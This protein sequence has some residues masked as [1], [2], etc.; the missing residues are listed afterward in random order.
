MSITLSSADL[1]KLARGVELL[2]SPLDHESADHWRSAVNRHVRELLC[3]DTAGFLLPVENGLAMYSDEHDPL[4]LAAFNEL[5]PPLLADGRTVWEEG[6]R[7]GVTTVERAYGREFDR[8]RGSAYYHEYAAVNRANDTLGATIAVGSVA[9][10]AVASLHFWHD[11]PVGRLFGERELGLLRLLFPA[12]QAGVEAQIRWGDERADLFRSLDVLGHAAI[13][14]NCAGT[15]LHQTPALT[16]MLAADPEAVSLSL[17]LRVATNA[18]R[19]AAAGAR[20]FTVAGAAGCARK[21]QTASARYAVRGCV[22]GGP[23]RGWERYLLVS[24]ERLSPARRPDAELREAFGL[25][26]AELR[27]AA[28]LTEGRTNSEIARELGVTEHTA[29]RHTERILQKMGIHSRAQVAI[30]MHV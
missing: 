30:R 14:F 26:R 2:V 8:F 21:V 22:Y 18:L 17:E 29:R 23:P 12:F 9:P 11:Q 19:S 6:V 4:A 28:L 20:G 5:Q 10:D 16:G 24:L 15:P 27:V 7:A 3:A 1:E 13:V 25:T